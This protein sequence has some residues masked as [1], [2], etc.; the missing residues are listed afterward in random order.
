MD[1]HRVDLNLLV[2][3]NH[4]IHE[5]R[6]T[7]VAEILGLTQ[8]T[9]SNSL[10]RL[11]KLLGDEL[12]TP[13]RAGLVPTQFAEQLAGPVAQ[14]LAIIQES[15]VHETHF[16]PATFRRSMTIGM[17]DIGEIV[18]LPRLVERIRRDAP[19]VSLSTIRNVTTTLRE[20]MESGAV[21]LAI[22]LLPQL[23]TGF[24]QRRLFNQRYVCLFR[25][26]HPLDKKTLSLAD[27]K[28]AEHLVVVSAGTGHGKIDELIERAGVE[29]TVRL[30][31]PNYVGVGHILRG[32]SLCATVP[33]RLAQQ[34][35]ETDALVYRKHPVRLPDVA[36]SV[37]WHAKVHRSPAHQWLR[38][39]V[40]DLF[41]DRGAEAP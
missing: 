33:E 14:A 28:S 35:C 13:T 7:K 6:V 19:G 3:F 18:F 4:L 20:G 1:L 40:F 38:N 26:G 17:N 37:L 16:D 31:V 15:L 34:L 12:F 30:T 36:I 21:D 22:G 25:K 8:P 32:T 9:V 24:Y 5:R 10:G 27:F 29:R 41:A 23:K 39:I 2:L 11:R